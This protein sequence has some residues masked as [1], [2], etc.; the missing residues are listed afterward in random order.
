M[1]NTGKLLYSNLNT[2]ETSSFVIEFENLYIEGVATVKEG[3]L[4]GCGWGTD[5]GVDQM[6]CDTDTTIELE[7]VADGEGNLIEYN[8]LEIIKLIAEL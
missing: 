1:L 3:E 8:E 6:E 2:E 5:G 7:I 4:Y